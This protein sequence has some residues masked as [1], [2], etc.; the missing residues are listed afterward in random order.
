MTAPA[1]PHLVKNFCSDT[2]RA[3]FREKRLAVTVDTVTKGLEDL[4]RSLL[5]VGQTMEAAAGEMNR[6]AAAHEGLKKHLEQLKA[7]RK[8]R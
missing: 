7:A 4:G 3:A 5:V 6:M 1:R 2:C 8:K